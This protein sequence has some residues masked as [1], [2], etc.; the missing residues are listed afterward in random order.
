MCTHCRWEFAIFWLKNIDTR[1]A[2][3]WWCPFCRNVFILP[4]QKWQSWL[5]YYRAAHTCVPCTAV[6][7]KRGEN[8]SCAPRQ[9]M[10]C[11][12]HCGTLFPEYVYFLWHKTCDGRSTPHEYKPV[13]VRNAPSC[14]AYCLTMS[15]SSSLPFDHSLIEGKGCLWPIAVLLHIP[16]HLRRV[17]KLSLLFT[18]ISVLCASLFRF[19]SPPSLGHQLAAEPGYHW[20]DHLL[21]WA[22]AKSGGD[23]GGSF[24]HGVHLTG[25]QLRGTWI[26][27]PD[28]RGA[29]AGIFFTWWDL[30]TLP[31]QDSEIRLPQTKPA[32]HIFLAHSEWERVLQARI[33]EYLVPKRYRSEEIHHG[34]TDDLFLHKENLWMYLSSELIR[35]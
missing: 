31:W 5:L 1:Q 4:A 15:S 19:L 11:I 7:H 18:W 35:R 25:R 30:T 23:G 22:V 34:K 17:K 10:K 13:R 2:E 24:S 12:S 8:S 20:D 32:M 6:F 33:Q 28:I 16:A 9:G 3:Q 29:K 14:W 26:P 27:E 21:S